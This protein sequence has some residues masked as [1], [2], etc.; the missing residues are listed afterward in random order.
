VLID[1]HVHLLPPWRLSKLMQWMHRLYPQH[2]VPATIT[3]EECIADYKR[4]GVDYF[5]NLA[6]PIFAN[7]TEGLIDFNADLRRQ[8]P[9]IVPWGSLHVENPD[10]ARIVERII[11]RED[12]L[13]LKFHPFIQRFDPGDP[14]MFEAY[15]RLSE[16]GRPVV[17][18]T[19]FEELYGGTL[20]V[21]TM[22]RLVQ[23]FPRLPFVFAH[24]LFPEFG[25]AWRILD[26]YDNVWLEMTNVFGVLWDTRYPSGVAFVD[27]AQLLDGLAARSDRVMFG[28]DHP[29]GMGSLEEIY[30]TLDTLGLSETVKENLLGETAR[31]F[32][33]RFKPGFFDAPR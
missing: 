15:Q 17:F 32:V 22:E 4:L 21:A 28:S 13:G 10:K 2:P 7:E 6:Y 31:R 18:H 5:F 30:R 19:G 23:D 14:R 25:E 29:A 20:P 24:S 26:R 9:W 33:L 8:Y 12:F 27:K 16:L 1:V 11:V 3:L